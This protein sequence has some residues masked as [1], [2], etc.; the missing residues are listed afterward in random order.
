MTIQ[1]SSG[2]DEDNYESSTTAHSLSETLRES[3][4]VLHTQAERAGVINDILRGQASRADYALLLRNLLPAYERMEA[5]LDRHRATPAVGAVARR[6]LYRS[7]ALAAD[8]R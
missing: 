3:T 2:T 5:G 1:T 7:A 8:L 6:E 4:R